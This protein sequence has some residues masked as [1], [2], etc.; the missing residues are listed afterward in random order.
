MG[1]FFVS[2]FM[3]SHAKEGVAKCLKQCLAVFP[4]GSAFE[5]L[6]CV[7]QIATNGTV[8]DMDGRRQLLNNLQ[9]AMSMN[10][11]LHTAGDGSMGELSHTGPILLHCAM[12][13]LQYMKFYN[14]ASATEM[15]DMVSAICALLFPAILADVAS[16]EELVA[17]SANHGFEQISLP[18]LLEYGTLLLQCSTPDQAAELVFKLMG[19]QLPLKASN[20]DV[21]VGIA[22]IHCSTLYLQA[23]CSLGIVTGYKY[24]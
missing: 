10:I 9:Q 21:L 4:S 12:A 7:L 18:L 3:S 11:P 15:E 16:Q 6:N 5:L 20:T 2:P 13:V 24:Y 22:F 1:M 17:V 23:A 14:C 8:A 19:N